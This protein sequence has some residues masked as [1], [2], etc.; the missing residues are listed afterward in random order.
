MNY[1]TENIK[2]YENTINTI[3]ECLIKDNGLFL[4]AI[5]D[6]RNMGFNNSLRIS[7]KFLKGL[8][9]GTTKYKTNKVNYLLRKYKLNNY[10][11]GYRYYSL[12]GVYSSIKE[13]TEFKHIKNEKDFFNLSLSNSENEEL[14]LIETIYKKHNVGLVLTPILNLNSRIDKRKQVLNT[15]AV[16]VKS[17]KVSV[18]IPY[19][20][21]CKEVLNFID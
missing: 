18:G 9:T 21:N 15:G 4:I 3:R 17:D 6:L 5:R 16:L 13:I 10:I 8:L 12:S 11:K 2:R 20:V 1:E 7:T 14:N 19:K